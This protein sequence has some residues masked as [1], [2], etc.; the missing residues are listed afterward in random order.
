[1]Y[2]TNKTDEFMRVLGTTYE[3]NFFDDVGH[4][5]ES[6]FDKSGILLLPSF[7]SSKAIQALQKEAALLAGQA[8][9]SISIYNLY[10][11]PDDKNFA[12]LAPRN[13]KFRTIK[14]CIA[15]DRI[16]NDS[17]LR[18]IYNADVFRKFVCKLQRITDI[19]PYADM[20][21]NIN[22]NYYNPGDSLE[23]HFDNSDFAITLLVK[24]CAKGGIYEY[25]PNMRY[26]QNGKENYEL[27]D[28]ILDG[29]I[30]PKRVTMEDGDLMIFRGN[31]SLHRVTKIE[32]GERILVTLNYN[33]KPM[34]P[35]S[36]K[37]RMTFFG[38]VR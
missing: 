26:A 24:N 6:E 1:M 20:L 30:Q 14:S 15:D 11:L 8:Y 23:W 5:L 38:R 7:L 19:F 34:I 22:I 29:K 25:F 13:R 33:V 21:S 35:L 16:P 2:T 32:R 9:R 37:S 3:A 31:R 12:P 17:I 36:E 10:V 27:L 18:K 4:A 28:E